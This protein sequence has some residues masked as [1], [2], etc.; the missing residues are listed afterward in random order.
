MDNNILND[1]GIQNYDS[2]DKVL[3]QPEMPQQKNRKCLNKIIKEVK[4]KR[5][6]LKGYKAAITKEFK[7]GSISE[8]ARQMENKTIGNTRV[9]L[10]AYI[11]HYENK[12]K[13][14]KGSGL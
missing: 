12:V 2:Y 7:N 8:V 13:T 11:K 6:Q 10:N 14:M 4:N 5:N 3:N 1:L 9:T